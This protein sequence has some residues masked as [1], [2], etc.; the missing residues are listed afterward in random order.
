VQTLQ[1]ITKGRM[2]NSL[3]IVRKLLKIFFCSHGNR[4]GTIQEGS[5]WD[6]LIP[7]PYPVAKHDSTVYKLNP[8]L[9][10]NF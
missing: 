4:C 2:Y 5:F 1:S 6:T 3:W 7:V 9:L 8:R 10:A